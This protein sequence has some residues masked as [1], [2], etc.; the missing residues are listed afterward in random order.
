HIDAVAG[1]RRKVVVTGGWSR[2]E[3][4]MATKARLGGVQA[5]P[6]IEAG[7]RGA[8]LLAGVAAGVFE[9]ADALPPVA[10]PAGSP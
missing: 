5:P 10:V 4:V 1:P 2:D 8:A 3:A 6:V 9:S 7:A